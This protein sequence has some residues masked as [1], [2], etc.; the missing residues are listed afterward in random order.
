TPVTSIKG[1]VETL[2]D[3]AMHDPPDTE[4]FLRIVAKQADRLHAVIEDLLSLSKIEQSE[5]HETIVL[6][7][8]AVR[9]VLETALGVCQAAAGEHQIEVQ[10]DCDPKL[11]AALNAPLM[12][13]A[14]VNLL[15]NAIKYSEP[16]KQVRIRAQAVNGHARISVQDHGVGIAS[17]H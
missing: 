4:R 2:L 12:E 6:E 17:E 1:F 7:P 3:G 15:D 9:G 5:D 13:Q 11:Q 10:L 16:G 8:T 14:V